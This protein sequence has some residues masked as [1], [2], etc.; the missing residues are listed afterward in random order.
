MK[1][2]GLK[3]AL[4]LM[5]CT[6]IALGLVTTSVFAA[7]IQGGGVGNWSELPWPGGAVPGASDDVVLLGVYNSITYDMLAP[8][9]VRSISGNSVILTLAKNLEAQN[10]YLRE[11]TIADGGNVLTV[12]GTLSNALGPD[13]SGNGLIRTSQGGSLVLG[14]LTLGRTGLFTFFPGDTISG[15]YTTY[16]TFNTWPDVTVTQSSVDGSKLDKGLSFENE[17]AGALVL[18]RTLKSNQAEI[19]LNWNPDGLNGPIDWTLRW[20]GDHATD[21]RNYYAN[22]QIIDGTKPPNMIFDPLKNIFFDSATGYTYVG[23]KPEATSQDLAITV[24]KTEFQRN[25]NI[26]AT[27]INPPGGAL[28]WIALAA[29][30]AGNHTYLDWRYVKDLGNPKT[31]TPRAQPAGQYEFRLFLNNGFQL[32][33]KSSAVRVVP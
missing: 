10:L 6:G 32:A 24:T 30:G 23:F 28:D 5:V 15:S 20:K 1:N 2:P 25:E 27:I 22:G 33:A 21:L 14:N 31:W 29:V 7:K 12:T 17:A 4:R 3:K 19:T 18:G 16:S 9:A 8:G 26:I 11:G 13:N